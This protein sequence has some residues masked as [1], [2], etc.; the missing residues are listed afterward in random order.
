MKLICKHKCFFNGRS[1]KP[2]D[3]VDISPALAETDL[4]KASFKAPEGDKPAEPGKPEGD[5]LSPDEMKRRLT[6]WGVAFTARIS[7][8]DL[9]KL[10]TTQLQAQAEK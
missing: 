6:E 10:Y 7:K 3:V 8:A 5:E 2:G 4:V 1:V 9:V